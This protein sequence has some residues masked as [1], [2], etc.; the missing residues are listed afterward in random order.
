ME[1]QKIISIPAEAILAEA[2][3]MKGQGYRLAAISCTNK[4]GL[5]LSYSFEKNYDFIN[6]RINMDYETELESISCL[7]P[8]AFLYENEIVELHGAK[9][10]NIAVDFKDKLYRISTETP[11]KEKKEEE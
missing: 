8:F 2:S 10:N 9:I 3:N 11:F 5:E 6:L 1:E 4:N 7:Y